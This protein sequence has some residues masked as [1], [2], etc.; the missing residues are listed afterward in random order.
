M[1]YKIESARWFEW[2]HDL[3]DHYPQLKQFP[4]DI[5]RYKKHGG[6]YYGTNS[7][8]KIYYIHLYTMEQMNELVKIVGGDIVISNCDV[9]S[10]DRF[11][12]ITIY[13]DYLE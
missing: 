1:R 6:E 11:Y 2:S 10:E 3:L 5:K 12:T 7:Y 8:Y 13:D 9:Y 4:L